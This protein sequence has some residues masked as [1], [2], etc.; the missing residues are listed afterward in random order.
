MLCD[1]ASDKIFFI[2]QPPATCR[3]F[4]Y[5]ISQGRPC[6]LLSTAL[7]YPPYPTLWGL[8]ISVSRRVF[9]RVFGTRST[10]W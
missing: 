6:P 4:F 1:Q 10:Q 5:K 2:Y 3:L 7:V 9:S 8:C